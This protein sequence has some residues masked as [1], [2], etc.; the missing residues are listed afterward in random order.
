M[1]GLRKAKNASHALSEADK[2]FLWQ[3]G[4]LGKHSAQ[5]SVNVNFKNVTE[6]LWP[7]REARALFNDGGR[8]QHHNNQS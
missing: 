5:A 7:S 2:E 6:Q 4:Q 1:R 3:S 8:F